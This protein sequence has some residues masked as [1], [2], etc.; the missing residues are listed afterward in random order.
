MMRQGVMALAVLIA[1][2]QA[3]RAHA[4]RAEAQWSAR[5]LTG[6]VQMRADRAPD[7]TYG[8]VG[9]LSLAVS[10]GLSNQLDLGVELLSFVTSEPDFENASLTLSD[11]T[12]Y[13]TYT[14]REGATL[15]L[16]GATWRYGVDWVPVLAVSGGAGV[17]YRDNGAFSPMRFHPV[18]DHAVR[19]LDVALLG[20]A[21]IERRVNR[22]LTLGAY[23]A[24]LTDWSPDAPLMASLSL[25][26]GISYVHYPAAVN[27][28][29]ASW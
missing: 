5:T 19:V 3:R 29:R 28:L 14:R 23:S 8:L 7:P 11:D 4:D 21:G 15:F 18:E 13:S 24:L 9:G 16:A 6:V 22:S 26:L 10:Y 2:Y 27:R 12:A 17:R 20:K 25:S 1:L